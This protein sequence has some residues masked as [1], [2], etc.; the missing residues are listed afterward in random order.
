MVVL[1]KG[2]WY[3]MDNSIVA[4]DWESEKNN[5]F[6]KAYHAAFLFDCLG[7][8]WAIYVYHVSIY[9][10]SDYPLLSIRRKHWRIFL[11]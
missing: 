3:V 7:S 9:I 1:M 2:S 11:K 8:I 6:F 4:V 5:D 10:A